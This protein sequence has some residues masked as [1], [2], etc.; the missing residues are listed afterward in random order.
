MKAAV[1]CAILGSLA[2]A[3]PRE[4]P[5]WTHAKTAHFD[6]YSNS[7]PDSAHA[8]A[9]SFERLRAFFVRQ[10]DLSPRPQR[11]LRVICFATEQE[12]ERYRLRA[13][14]GAYFIGAESRDYIVL[15][16]PPNGELR[17]AAHEYAHVLIHSGAWN[18]PDWLAEGLGDVISTLQI[19]D[20]ETRI[21]GDLPSRSQ[22]L[23]TSAWLPLREL[24][25]FSLKSPA[26]LG[27][28]RLFY[29]QSWALTDLLMM[30]PAYSPGFP[31]LL[32]AL[33]SGVPAEQA[34]STVYH[35]PLNAIL[36]DVRA[37]LARHP[38]WL[39]LPPL[40]GP[41]P[42]VRATTLSSFDTRF[43]LA[44]L[45]LAAGDTAA[46][47]AFRQ[48]VQERPDSAGLHAALGAIA[49]KHGNTGE[50]VTEW[51]RAVDLRIDDADL[52][53]RYA[54]LA[55]E[56]GFPARDALLRALALRPE[57]D[58]ARFKLA[59][60]EKNA[61]RAAEAVTQL[62][63]MRKIDAKRAFAYWSAMA[64]AYLDLNRRDEAKEAAGKAREHAANTGERDRA[65][66]L[67][68]LADTE[69]A[70][71]IEDRKFRTVRV[72]VGGAPRNPFI[73]TG[74]RAQRVEA[75]LRNVECGESGIQL[76]VDSEKGALT[77]AVPNPARVQIRNAGAEA[78]EFV[79]GPQD[80]R[81][82][83]IE[84]A[85]QTSLLRGLEFK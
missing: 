1:L 48:L 25:E 40:T 72:P 37:R 80:A 79:C 41:Q 30:S 22:T 69:L 50:A 63:A 5:V 66:E 75:T 85:P 56:R 49:L 52:C 20:R 55:D 64:D 59:L 77:L 51:K 8:L 42:E 65:I 58:D 21:G 11:E 27:R 74:D 19:R 54:A 73:E 46:E 16:A 78:F 14:T 4:A 6:I 84:Y 32:A 26:S 38:G 9:A 17:A 67:A 15:P 13:G 34:L 53:F 60:L 43:M 23:R 83:L 24:F 76:T 68:W 28:E 81:K 57:F 36:S 35:V 71:E 39:A 7:G 2:F 18:L 31:A 29:A 47:A 61:G 44:D 12:Y 45:R 62:R 3:A 33:A 70:V 10:V 82:V